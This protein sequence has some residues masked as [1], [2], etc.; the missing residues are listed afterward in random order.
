MRSLAL[1]V[2]AVESSVITIERGMEQLKPDDLYS[3]EDYASIRSVFRDKVV[4]LQKQRRV[5]LG[6]GL[7]VCFESKLTVQ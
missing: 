7:V 3:L 2:L 6:Q 5:Q 4:A 1:A